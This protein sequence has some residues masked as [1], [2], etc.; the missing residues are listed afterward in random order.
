MKKSAPGH[1]KKIEV[2]CYAGYKANERPLYFVLE[3]QKREV[4]EVSAQWR[5]QDHDCFKV[6]ADDEM[7]YLLKWDRWRDQWVLG[8]R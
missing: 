1:D 3:G 2:I 4:C 5:D 6:V 7:T 8:K